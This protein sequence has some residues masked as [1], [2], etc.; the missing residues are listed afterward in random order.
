MTATPNDRVVIIHCLLLAIFPFARVAPTPNEP[1]CH[2]LLF[3]ACNIACRCNDATPNGGRDV[4]GATLAVA[5][6]ATNT[7]IVGY[8]L[9]ALLATNTFVVGYSLV[10]LLAT[11]TFVVGYPL[12]D[13]KEGDRKGRPYAERQ[14][15]LSRL[16]LPL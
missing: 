2:Y 13:R 3:I 7:F 15:R 4:V 16:F 10:A 8:P 14:G 5:L 11:N 6:L 1:G 12:G 9:V